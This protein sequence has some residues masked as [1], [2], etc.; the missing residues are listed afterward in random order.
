[1][2]ET[3]DIIETTTRLTEPPFFKTLA[4]IDTSY[5]RVS[6]EI[7][8]KHYKDKFNIERSFVKRYFHVLDIAR[9]GLTFLLREVVIDKKH[10]TKNKYD[11]SKLQ[12]AIVK[13]N[14][15]RQQLDKLYELQEALIREMKNNM[16]RLLSEEE[17]KCYESKE[18]IKRFIDE[19]HPLIYLDIDGKGCVLDYIKRHKEKSN[20]VDLMVTIDKIYLFKS[21]KSQYLFSIKPKVDTI[22]YVGPNNQQN[23]N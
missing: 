10:I 14:N 23:I 13:A 4:S 6:P 5:I 3:N 2:T 12:L 20:V 8:T 15:N 19:S 1:M 17:I 11:T 7:E 18:I 9:I 21:D 22:I 16:H